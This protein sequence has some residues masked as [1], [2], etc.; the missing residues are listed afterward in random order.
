MGGR[1]AGSLSNLVGSGGKV[2]TAKSKLS[3]AVSSENPDA[4]AS[5][6]ANLVTKSDVGLEALR[7]SLK[8]TPFISDNARRLAQISLSKRD[9]E[10]RKAWSSV[11]K[12]SNIRTSP[13][14]DNS[15]ISAAL[16][17]FGKGDT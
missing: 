16:A 3:R 7:F 13:E 10:I 5:A 11:K 17:T 15:V 4:I 9:E 12:T 1:R 2:T 8:L 14:L 6:A